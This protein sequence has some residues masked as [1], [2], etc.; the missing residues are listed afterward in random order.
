MTQEAPARRRP[1]PIV[2]VAL[3]AAALALLFA[4]RGPV[5]AWFTGRPIGQATSR[6]VSTRAGG[7]SIDA[8][9]EPDPPRPQGN[10]LLLTVRD[11]AAAPVE[12]AGIAVEASMAAMGSMPAMRS[13]A[14]VH[15][16]GRGRYRADFDLPVAGTWSPEVTVRS[17]RGSAT[18]RYSLTTGS[19]GL[20]PV[21]AL[22]G[23]GPAGAPGSRGDI[24][25]Y[26][27]SMHP[28]V[29]QKAPGQCPIC[30]M[31]LVP[32][33]RDEA[34]S[35]AV[36]LDDGRR[37]EIG[38]RTG[39]AALQ[40]LAQRVTTVGRVA[41]DESRLH[42]V[43]VKFSGWIGTLDASQ[44]GQRVR[45][46]QTLFTLYSPELYAA[47]EEYLTALASQRA[48]RSTAAPDRA[49]YLV[50]AARRKLRLWDL[51]ERE[52][53]A[54]AVRGEPIR[55]VPVRSPVS[56]LV[57]EKTVVQGASVAAG[58]R[59]F[60]IAN[61]DRVWVEAQ[62][63]EPDIPR[64]RLGGLA[65]ITLRALPGRPLRGRVTLVEPALAA[66]SRTASVRIEVANPIGDAGPLLRPDMYADVEF[67]GASR[68]ALLVPESAVLYTGMRTIV[69]VDE[70]GGRFTPREVQLGAKA[71]GAYEVVAGLQ[72]GDRV[73]TSGNFLLDAES[74]L[75]SARPESGGE[76]GS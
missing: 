62:V 56:G 37:Q 27:C 68:Q 15:R 45:A 8:T 46:G 55:E 31:D 28:A 60:R 40:P 53:R 73:V 59:L 47:E 23:G 33:R 64:V 12:D 32:V 54:L 48:A 61:L 13:R 26:T 30:G 1:A 6:A 35:G 49:D 39:V 72:A 22:A 2:R 34:E 9:L 10:S 16:E 25:Y 42:D 24:A 29:R 4:F 43:S 41:F 66:E 75:K 74:R 71:D 70:G 36:V 52:I 65:V 20:T 51:D 11:A 58:T 69:F 5:I 17:A 50:D 7:L 14:K 3:A 38:L 21:D 76:G 63:Y 18:V 57:V 44:T 19:K 67:A